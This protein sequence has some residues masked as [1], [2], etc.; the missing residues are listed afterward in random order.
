MHS[1]S[2]TALLKESMA[3]LSTFMGLTS[4]AVI[5]LLLLFFFPLP[6]IETW[7]LGNFS[8]DTVVVRQASSVGMY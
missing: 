3:Y 5:F 7:E 8:S 4:I 6:V 1:P 2:G